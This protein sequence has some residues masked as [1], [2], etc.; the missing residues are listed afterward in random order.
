M[1]S[2]IINELQNCGTPLGAHTH[3]VVCQ[4]S[5]GAV[6]SHLIPS[7]LRCA[8]TGVRAL[9]RSARACCAGAGSHA[10]RARLSR[11]PVRARL[12]RAADT[13]HMNV[14]VCLSCAGAAS[15]TLLRMPIFRL[16]LGHDLLLYYISTQP[17]HRLSPRVWCAGAV[18]RC[19]YNL[20]SV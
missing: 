14:A 19:A 8:R 15:F 13:S 16:S 7:E 5:A 3:T 11:T 6:W 17:A 20:T 1:L 18:L 9:T 2:I 12:P 4:S 10:V